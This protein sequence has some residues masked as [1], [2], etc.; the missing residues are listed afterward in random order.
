[1]SGT[2]GN[3]QVALTW[4]APAAT[5]GYA[6]TDYAIQYSSNSGSTWTT[7]SH[8]ASTATAITVTSLTNNTAYVFRVAAV[9]TLG[10]GGFSSASASITPY[11]GLTFSGT[12]TVSN[13][14][15][16]TISGQGTPTLTLTK[17]TT[18]SW[19][20]NLNFSVGQACVITW[21]PGSAS[22]SS[23]GTS[24]PTQ[25]NSVGYI[26]SVV[27][28]IFFDQLQKDGTYYGTNTRFYMSQPWGMYLPAAGAYK[29]PWESFT[30]GTVGTLTVSDPASITSPLSVSGGT[31]N[32]M[33]WTKNTTYGATVNFTLSTRSAMFVRKA[34]GG[35]AG[36]I[37]TFNY[38]T[39][40]SNTPS[41]GKDGKYSNYAFGFI[42]VLPA[43]SYL[44]LGNP[45][46]IL[47]ASPNH[48]IAI[49]V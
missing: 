9:T 44:I 43:G 26:N 15:A 19:Q 34:Y 24:R 35:N 3:A 27:S 29:F 13:A 6:I 17:S 47:A 31:Q 37:T 42:E 18:A 4:T 45:A 41:L 30:S 39:Y 23:Y 28:N 10:A 2:A 49:P 20:G 36:L 33:V 25:T 48:F 7:F 12:A 21:T 32:G 46:T 5:G 1:V 8:S 16:P 38:T 22:A 14:N 11:T 40:G